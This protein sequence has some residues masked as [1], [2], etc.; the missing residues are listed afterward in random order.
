MLTFSTASIHGILKPRPGFYSRGGGDK[1]WKPSRPYHVALRDSYVRENW[2]RIRALCAYNNVPFD[3]TGQRINCDG[4]WCVYEF[5]RQED[6]LLFGIGL[7]DAGYAKTTFSILIG[8]TIF[9]L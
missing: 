8:P 9:P 4:H 1:R 2:D 7:R 3:P 5:A 6:A